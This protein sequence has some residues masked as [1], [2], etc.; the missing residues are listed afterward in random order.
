MQKWAAK[1][2]TSVGQTFNLT[3]AC[4]KINFQKHT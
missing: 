4:N 3:C 1:V 2:T